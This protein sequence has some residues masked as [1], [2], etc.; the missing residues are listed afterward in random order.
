MIYYLK[1]EWSPSDLNL[2][3]EKFRLN[4][5]GTTDPSQA[6]KGSIRGRIYQDWEQLG[7]EAQPNTG[8]NGIH[9]SASAFEALIERMNWCGDKLEE[10]PFGRQILNAGVT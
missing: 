5:L 2:S 1:V 6:D 3:W 10:D 9:G 8:L 4:V 7:L